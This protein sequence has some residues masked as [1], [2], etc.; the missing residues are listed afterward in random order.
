MADPNKNYILLTTAEQNSILNSV[1]VSVKVEEQDVTDPDNVVSRNLS[2][3]ESNLTTLTAQID[4]LMVHFGTKDISGDAVHKIG[5][6]QKWY[7]STDDCCMFIDIPIDERVYDTTVHGDVESVFIDVPYQYHSQT[8]GVSTSLQV[9]Q[10]SYVLS[11]PRSS[12]TA[13][14]KPSAPTLSAD[15]IVR[16]STKLEPEIII[17]NLDLENA[18]EFEII[19]SRS[20]TGNS[21]APEQISVTESDIVL[22]D[23]GNGKKAAQISF[24]LSHGWQ[25]F[26][27]KT[28]YELN[29]LYRR[30]REENSLY[31]WSDDSNSLLIFSSTQACPPQ[32]LP[33]SYSQKSDWIANSTSEELYVVVNVA[34]R[35]A[36]FT[37]QE[38]QF[39][40][41]YTGGTWFPKMSLER[42]QGAEVATDG[43][44]NTN[45][46]DITISLKNDFST[47]F[48]R[49]DAIRLGVEVRVQARA[50]EITLANGVV[51]TLTSNEMRYSDY[52]EPASFGFFNSS[53]ALWSSLITTS[54][55]WKA[56][57]L[58]N[59][60]IGAY[61]HSTTSPYGSRN[62]EFSGTLSW[63]RT[64]LEEDTGI[65][66]TKYETVFVESEYEAAKAYGASAEDTEQNNFLDWP[67][68]SELKI[69]YLDAIFGQKVDLKVGFL[70]QVKHRAS[71]KTVTIEE[72]GTVTLETALERH[73]LKL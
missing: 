12:F 8:K 1:R 33:A 73:Y 19:V 63:T 72:D 39:E 56:M 47:S 5:G 34:S 58:S 25:T 45:G 23:D 38:L 7:R 46:K 53:N 44:L 64:T 32:L 68:G 66:I 65:E 51:E 55:S 17:R 11:T 52:S 36:W 14:S 21:A 22:T 4:G 60:T 57:N 6:G 69:D 43:Q 71:G 30:R 2:L 54:S 24:E 9:G 48:N 27:P 29:V 49:E 59:R 50:S 15:D 41:R 70:G 40:A 31:L 18:Y 16:T 28:P 61:T 35:F 3:D 67:A 26:D 20:I 13:E 37:N 10:A 62:A 42:L